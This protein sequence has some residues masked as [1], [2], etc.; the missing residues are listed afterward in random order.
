MS[1]PD[2]LAPLDKPGRIHDRPRKKLDLVQAYKLRVENR[3][4]FAE[5]AKT[6]GVPKSTVHAALHRLNKL[7]PD[8]ETVKAFEGV[9]ASILTS[10]Q[11]QLLSSL[12]DPAKLEKAS[13]NNLAYG[14]TQL[15]TAHRLLTGA[16]TQNISVLSRLVGE[17]NAELF[18]P[19]K[20]E[21]A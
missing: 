21:R 7:V 4:T 8:P 12:L 18:K 9:Q 16:S 10:A 14:F 3:L 13:L 2:T 15:F 5:I 19:G 1:L 6:L 20:P 17:A 11:E